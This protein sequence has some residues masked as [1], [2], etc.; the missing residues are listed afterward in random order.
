MEATSF[1]N[2]RLLHLGFSNLTQIRTSV[3]KKH[4]SLPSNQII[5]I[6]INRLGELV[7]HTINDA[8]ISLADIFLDVIPY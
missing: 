7:L 2:F 4:E 3:T 6:S 5:S 8:I 1:F